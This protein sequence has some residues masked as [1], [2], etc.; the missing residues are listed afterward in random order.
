MYVAI[1]CY[2]F[3]HTDALLN[4]VEV[5]ARERNSPSNTGQEYQTTPRRRCLSVFFSQNVK[6]QK[7]HFATI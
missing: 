3:T 6:E 1:V 2:P 5:L 7:N 4:G